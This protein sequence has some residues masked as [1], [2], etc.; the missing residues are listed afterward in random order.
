MNQMER[1][2]EAAK[3]NGPK[4]AVIL[5]EEPSSQTQAETK[6]VSANFISSQVPAGINVFA[7]AIMD[8]LMTAV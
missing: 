8:K 2:G 7:I 1:N 5:E 4:G 6:D 3:T